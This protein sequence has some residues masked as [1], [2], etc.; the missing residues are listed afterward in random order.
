MNALMESQVFFFISSV[1]FVILGI[2]ATV[3]LIMFI[4]IAGAFSRIMSK[5]ERDIDRIGDTT[6]ELLDDFRSSMLF[7]M[8]FRHHRKSDHRKKD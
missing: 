8:F 7:R 3:V 5:I 6:R 4:R 1:G 2:L